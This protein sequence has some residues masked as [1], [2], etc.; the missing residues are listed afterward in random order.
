M[1][2]FDF[3]RSQN[4]SAPLEGSYAFVYGEQTSS[5]LA[6]DATAEE[7]LPLETGG[8]T[9]HFDLRHM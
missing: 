5:P 8:E 4:A 2:E 9:K 3:S 7:V 1:L 6:H